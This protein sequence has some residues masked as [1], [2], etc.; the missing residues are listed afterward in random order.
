MGIN[1]VGRVHG[2]VPE[3]DPTRDG[4]LSELTMWRET[5]KLLSERAK[6]VYYI[7][8]PDV[9]HQDRFFNRGLHDRTDGLRGSDSDGAGNREY[10]FWGWL[11]AVIDFYAVWLC[12]ATPRFTGDRDS[13]SRAEWLRLVN[14]THGLLS[15]YES[16]VV[17]THELGGY[18]HVAELFYT[19]RLANLER[20]NPNL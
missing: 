20:S 12:D 17:A 1:P 10:V 14:E 18:S 19:L 4:Y 13:G 16:D 9:E 15:R 8:R 6:Q 11:D 7:L 5:V 2:D 3:P